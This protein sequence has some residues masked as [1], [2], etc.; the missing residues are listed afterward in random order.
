MAWKFGVFVSVIFLAI[1]IRKIQIKIEKVRL[2]PGYTFNDE[3]CVLV[4]QGRGMVGT[5]DLALGKHSVLFITSGDLWT[6]FQHGPA[7]SAHGGIWMMDPRPGAAK[8]PVKLDIAGWPE[9]RLLHAHG[10]DVSN[11]T[12]RMYIVNH[13]GDH[14]SVEVVSIQYGGAGVRLEYVTSI[15]SPL[16]PVM[17]IN[18][19][20]EL[21]RDHVYVTQWQVW[22]FPVQ[23][24][25]HPSTVLETL[26][27]MTELPINLLGLKFTRVF[28]CT[29][30]TSDCVAASDEVF[31]GANGMTINSARDTVF[32]ND[33]TEKKISVMK[34][35]ESL[36]LIKESEIKLPVA[37][38]NIE[39]DDE[40]DEIL[41]G[42]IPDMMAVAQGEG[43]PEVRVPGGMALA[44]RHEAGGWRVRDV[45]EHDGSKLDQISAASRYAGTVILGSPHD[46]GV[47]VCDNVKY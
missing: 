36:Q 17:G 22:G 41:I 42:T 40:A 23:G 2:P 34:V 11:I 6:I 26:K 20:V 5:E 27:L 3:N 47:L 9:G 35:Q 29:V 38:D 31:V 18:D 13:H 4:G 33:P 1:L 25:Q 37:A 8:D 44:S 30:E 16:F 21:D 19:V 43:N 24:K 10:F 45:L 46:E 15:S 28:L 14:S 32:V 7:H 12:D 39:Y